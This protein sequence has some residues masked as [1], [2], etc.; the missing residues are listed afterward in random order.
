MTRMAKQPV[1]LLNPCPFCRE[2]KNGKDGGLYF[3]S[4]KEYT[5]VTCGDCGAR[6]PRCQN[7][8]KAR[9]EWNAHNGRDFG[10]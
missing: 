8:E 4:T 5:W 2:E 3:S 6:G 9:S 10:E 1:G 7:E